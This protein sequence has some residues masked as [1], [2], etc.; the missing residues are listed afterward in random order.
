[1]ATSSP[2]LGIIGAGQLAQMTL[3]PAASLGIT[4]KIL[5]AS[6]EDSAA[7]YFPEIGRAHV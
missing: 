5:A 1:M 6:A 4:L 3:A 2:V 7:Q